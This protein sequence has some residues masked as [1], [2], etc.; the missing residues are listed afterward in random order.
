VRGPGPRFKESEGTRAA[1]R[2]L[3]HLNESQWIVVLWYFII[4]TNVSC[5]MKHV[6]GDN[7]IFSIESGANDISCCSAK[8]ST[9]FSRA[10][11]PERTQWLPVLESHYSSVWVTSQKHW[12]NEAPTGQSMEKQQHLTVTRSSAIVEGPRDALC[13]LKSCQLLQKC[14]KNHTWYGLQRANDLENRLISLKMARLDWPYITSS[15]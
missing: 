4:L 2:P 1:R 6:V 15:Y 13:Q 5:Y 7:F 8:L 3:R 11:A 14:A 9:L 12:R 10:M